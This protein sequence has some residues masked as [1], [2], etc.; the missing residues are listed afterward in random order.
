MCSTEGEEI[1]SIGMAMRPSCSASSG[2]ILTCVLCMLHF[3]VC[4]SK[5]Q[6]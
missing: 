1:Y 3:V 2:E 5:S 4:G 6:A